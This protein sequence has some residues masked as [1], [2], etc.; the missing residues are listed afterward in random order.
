MFFT[1]LAANFRKKYTF[2]NNSFKQSYLN[3]FF[4]AN[5]V[6]ATFTATEILKGVALTFVLFLKV[7]L[8][9][10]MNFMIREKFLEFRGYLR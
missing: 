2:L 9:L 7:I 5:A 4:R 6:S 3:S 8:N 1:D 10:K